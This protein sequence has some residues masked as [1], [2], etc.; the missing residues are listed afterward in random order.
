MQTD[1]EEYKTLYKTLKKHHP[2]VGD[3]KI[4][5]RMYT[6]QTIRNE[7][8]AK[9]IVDYLA[10]NEDKHLLV[11]VGDGHLNPRPAIPGRVE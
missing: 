7:T 8:M 1:E 9:T 4:Y 3:D 5:K 2:G 11:I 10:K 6:A